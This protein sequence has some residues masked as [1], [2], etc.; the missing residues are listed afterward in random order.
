MAFDHME[1]Q[2]F[3]NGKNMETVFTGIKGTIYPVFYGKNDLKHINT[4]TVY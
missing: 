4:I 2:Y 1:F 3:L